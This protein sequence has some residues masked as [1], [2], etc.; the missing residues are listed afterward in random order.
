MCLCTY[1]HMDV[2]G[3]YLFIQG[4]FLHVENCKQFGSL[5]PVGYVDC[6]HLVEISLHKLSIKFEQVGV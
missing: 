5:K 2:F 1:M 4:I 3:R 6:F